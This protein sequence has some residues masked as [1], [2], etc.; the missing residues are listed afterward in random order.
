MVSK[1]EKFGGGGGGCL[2]LPL[3]GGGGK[4]QKVPNHTDVS[5]SCPR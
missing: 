3:L 5:G 1:C 2:P 4:G